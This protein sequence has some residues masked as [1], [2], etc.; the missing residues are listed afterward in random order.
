MTDAERDYGERCESVRKD[1]ERV[2]GILK[3]RFRVL[4]VPNMLQSDA[5]LSL[6]FKCCC[7]LHNMLLTHDGFSDIGQLELDWILADLADT[8]NVIRRTTGSTIDINA[9]FLRLGSQAT[10]D[11]EAE[12]EPT[13]HNLRKALTTHLMQLWKRIMVKWLKKAHECRA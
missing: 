4:R 10:A 2:F 9:D 5:K 13:F 11:V 3:Q 6:V 12:D 1:V 8:A 7:I